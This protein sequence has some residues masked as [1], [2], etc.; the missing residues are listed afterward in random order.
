MKVKHFPASYVGRF[1]RNLA[2]NADNFLGSD[3]YENIA[4]DA[5]I[6]MEGSKIHTCNK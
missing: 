5:N 3:F 2:D 4:N 1:Y 6:P